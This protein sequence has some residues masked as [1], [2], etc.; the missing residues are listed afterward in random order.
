LVDYPV[1]NV[2][3]LPAGFAGYRCRSVTGVP[4]MPERDTLPVIGGTYVCWGT[5]GGGRRPLEC[6]RP[7]PAMHQ[8]D[9]ETQV[10]SRFRRARW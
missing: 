8:V 3:A 5:F 7:W 9:I 10:E 1:I 2:G 4:V 6:H